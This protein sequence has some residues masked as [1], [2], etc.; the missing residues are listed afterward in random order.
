MPNKEGGK[1]RFRLVAVSA[2]SKRTTSRFAPVINFNVGET[3]CSGAVGDFNGDGQ[4][5]LAV[6]N[7][8]SNNVSVLLNKGAKGATEEVTSCSAGLLPA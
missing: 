8:D 3:P 7:A 5:D 2:K 1:N 4:L 6:A